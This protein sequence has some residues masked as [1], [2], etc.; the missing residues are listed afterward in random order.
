MMPDLDYADATAEPGPAR[1]APLLA[2]LSQMNGIEFVLAIGPDRNAAHDFWGL[3][4]PKP[5]A[6]FTSETLENFRKLGERLQLGQLQQVVGTGPQRKVAVAS[7]GASQLC[8]GFP[9]T[10]G[11]DALRDTMRNILTKWAS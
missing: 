9:S 2:E 3:E 4:N 10:M 6:E 11:A 7:C 1:I 5:V 8:V